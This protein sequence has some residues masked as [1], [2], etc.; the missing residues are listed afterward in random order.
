MYTYHVSPHMLLHSNHTMKDP[1][2]LDNCDHHFC[3]YDTQFYDA[4]ISDVCPHFY[5][6]GLLAPVL[7]T[8]CETLGWEALH[9]YKA[10]VTAICLFALSH[11]SSMY[12]WVLL[13]ACFRMCILGALSGRDSC[14]PTCRLPAWVKDLKSNRQL[15]N[16]IRLLLHMK[17]LTTGGEEGIREGGGGKQ[18]ER[19]QLSECIEGCA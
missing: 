17:E 4:L 11:F 18:L 7:V 13:I 6:L 9:E 10:K 16:M 8:W 5:L 1:C 14:C 12:T 15:A 3:R 19:V 2:T